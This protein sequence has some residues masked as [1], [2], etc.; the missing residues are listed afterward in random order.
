MNRIQRLS[1]Q[2]GALVGLLPAEQHL[3]SWVTVKRCTLCLTFRYRSVGESNRLSKQNPKHGV[4]EGEG[5]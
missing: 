1:S 5:K 2:Q 3:P 4:R